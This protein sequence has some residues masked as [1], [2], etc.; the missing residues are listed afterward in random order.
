MTGL[1]KANKEETNNTMIKNS[2]TISMIFS[3]N[4]RDRTPISNTSNSEDPEESSMKG[5]TETDME[6]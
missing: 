4:S 2:I 1:G 6:T 3:T 5:Y